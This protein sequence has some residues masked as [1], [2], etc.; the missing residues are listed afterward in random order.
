MRDWL[1]HSHAVVMIVRVVAGGG[2]LKCIPPS[3]VKLGVAI[4]GRRAGHTFIFVE[5]GLKYLIVEALAF[6]SILV[7]F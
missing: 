1:I 7:I 6:Q 2:V 4:H 5:H 3:H